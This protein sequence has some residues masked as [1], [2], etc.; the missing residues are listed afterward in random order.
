MFEKG[1][2]NSLL[3]VLC[4][5]VYVTTYLTKYSYNANINRIM[6]F[7]NVNHA[8]AGLVSTFFFF[9]Y[10]MGQ[11]IHGVLSKHYNSR[12]LVSA[13]LAVS[14][15][16][17]IVVRF[18]P[19]FYPVK[20]LWIINGFTLS[21]IW[22]LIVKTLAE[23]LESAEFDKAIV[24][25][26][27]T[28]PAGLLITYGLSSFYIK[29]AA[30]TAIFT[31]A[32][33]V[34][35]LVAVVWL[36]LFP[37]LTGVRSTEIIGG[38]KKSLSDKSADDGVLT[39]KNLI[40]YVC[41]LA[42]MSAVASVIRDGISVWFPS[43]LIEKFGFDESVSVVMS[44]VIPMF[45]ILGNFIG[46]WC[47]KRIKDFILFGVIFMSASAVFVSASYF[48]VVCVSAVLLFV[49]AGASSCLLYGFG[50][51]MTGK[52]PMSVPDKKNSG[53]Y[54]G[55]MNGA[56]YVGSTISTYGLGLIA[57]KSGWNGTFL[58]LAAISVVSAIVF[59]LFYTGYKL[60]VGRKSSETTDKK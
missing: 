47:N 57:D 6:P 55:V 3:I 14:A 24:V 41:V 22:P 46:V 38:E 35:V 17:N 15:V 54:A 26:G 53:F 58:S 51:I 36:I 7:F 23:N 50:N 34:S 39:Q 4:W 59:A 25:M 43:I 29:V 40:L 8:E 10:G 28:T 27:T 44:L 31:T 56:T 9:S 52:V 42:L 5:L 49:G 12:Y 18:C 48:G 2:K 37:A 60:F 30:F 1:K 32:F 13:A 21:L 20:F 11:I 19:V 16:I 45:G 33:V